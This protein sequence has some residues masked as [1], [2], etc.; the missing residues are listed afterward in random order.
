MTFLIDNS[1]S[2]CQYFKL[3]FNLLCFLSMFFQLVL[4][5]L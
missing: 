4:Q 2:N 5:F 3:F 1:V